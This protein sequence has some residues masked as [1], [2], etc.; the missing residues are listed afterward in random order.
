MKN[1]NLKNLLAGVIPA[2]VTEY[3][4][5]NSRVA[6]VIVSTVS[7][8]NTPQLRAALQENLGASVTPI[9]G[10]FR[11]LSDQKNSLI[12]FVALATPQHLVDGDPTKAGYR[13][14]ASNMYMSEA[15]QSVWELKAGASAQYMV[16]QGQDDLRELLENSR[17]TP[18][19]STPRMASVIQ[20]SAQPT[21]LVA[22]VNSFGNA[23]PAVDFGFCLSSDKDNNYTMI[24]ATYDQPIKV[25]ASEIV[26]IYA[27]DP[28]Q[29]HQ[30]IQRGAA[31]KS[32]S[33]TAASDKS[34]MIDYYKRLYSY[35]PDY[36]KLVIKEINEMAAF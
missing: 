17:A 3:S 5:V 34:T 13:L 26:S 2:A 11:W 27:L 20:A 16:R 9:T 8:V 6:R 19:G 15:D 14:V 36:L 25:S 23:Q 35:A 22:F 31:A 33:V 4:I 10:S 29:V 7:N 24:T 12:G 21:E 18:R 28:N 32:V 1:M 30:Q